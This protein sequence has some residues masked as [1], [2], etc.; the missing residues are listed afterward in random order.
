MP[1]NRPNVSWTHTRRV[2]YRYRSWKSPILRPRLLRQNKLPLY[3]IILGLGVFRLVYL[4]IRYYLPT[5]HGLLLLLHIMVE[6]QVKSIFH[7]RATWVRFF[8]ISSIIM[9]RNVSLRQYFTGVSN[10]IGNIFN[11]NSDTAYE[12]NN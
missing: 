6:I 5:R 9:T 11:T 10:N 8:T 2:P 4:T 7:R 1:K 3:I 12:G